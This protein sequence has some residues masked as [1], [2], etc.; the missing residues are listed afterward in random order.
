MKSRRACL[1]LCGQ[2]SPPS[3]AAWIEILCLYKVSDSVHGR[4]LHGRRGLKY[5]ITDDVLPKGRSPP[6]RAAWIEIII[7]IQHAEMCQS[8]PSRAAWI[9]I[10]ICLRQHC[11]CS[12]P[13]SRAAWIEIFVGGDGKKQDASPPSRAAWIEMVV[14]Y[15]IGIPGFGRRLHGRR[16]LKCL[17]RRAGNQS[18]KSP[19]SRAAWIEM[20]FGSW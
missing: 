6:S 12:S 15:S 11:L 2:W 3:R 19:P 4:R 10:G 17:L 8:P 20:G 14:T 9:E 18:L 16:G 1:S 5:A 7:V 13:P